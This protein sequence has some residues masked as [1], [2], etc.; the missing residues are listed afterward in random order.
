M[1]ICIMEKIEIEEFL[2]PLSKND[3][4]EVIALAEQKLNSSLGIGDSVTLVIDY[5]IGDADGDT[6]KECGLDIETQDE[7]DALNI[8]TYILDNHTEPN[9]GTWGFILDESN[10]SKKS[11]DVYNILYEQGEAPEVFNG[12]NITPRILEVIEYIVDDCFRGETE[13][14]FLVYEGYRL[15]Q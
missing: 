4:R 3:L 15:E 1:Y 9:E 6:E 11:N 10:F 2:K 13:Y 14:S 12:V 8:I 5:M 7:L